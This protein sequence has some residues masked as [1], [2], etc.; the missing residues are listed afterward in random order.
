M[1]GWVYVITN[2]AMPGLVKV[3]FSTKDPD[4]RA[5]E[6][7]NT[8]APHPYKVQYEVLVEHPYGVEQ[9]AHKILKKNKEG[10]EWF[11]CEVADAIAAIK[12]VANKKIIYEKNKHQK[13]AIPKEKTSDIITNIKSN[14]VK[15]NSVMLF[16]SSLDKAID[17]YKK[18]DIIDAIK[19]FN[20]MGEEGDF[21]SC[22]I[23]AAYYKD[24]AIEQ[25]KDEED[26]RHNENYKKAFYWSQKATEVEAKDVKTNASI[27]A[28]AN[29]YYLIGVLYK[30]GYGTEQNIDKAIFW[31]TKSGAAGNES[32]KR[33]LIEHEREKVSP[34]E[35]VKRWLF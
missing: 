17:Q 3:G 29:I 18:G 21:L 33:V 15:T 26:L 13:T 30:N 35:R 19:Q 24:M 23:L 20:K 5:K 10:K 16:H 7:G 11:R 32:A 28:K 1:K 2:K 9:K 8:G 6:L 12:S 34:L 27:K 22:T 25:C 14:F 4:L 31:L